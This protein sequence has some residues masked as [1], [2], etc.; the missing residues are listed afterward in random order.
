MRS[1]AF[2]RR[3]SSLCSR[4]LPLWRGSC[5]FKVLSLRETQEASATHAILVSQALATLATLVFPPPPSV[6]F[7]TMALFLAISLPC[8]SRNSPTSP[9]VVHWSPSSR[10]TQ[11]LVLR[12]CL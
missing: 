7:L 9:K 1:F 11:V 5:A 12:I 8:Q 10:L 6:F 3:V 4:Q 2:K